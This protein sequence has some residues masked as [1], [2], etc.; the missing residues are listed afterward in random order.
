MAMDEADRVIRVYA[1]RVDEAADFSF[2][3]WNRQGLIVYETDD[4]NQAN[5]VGWDGTNSRN[6]AEIEGGTYSYRVRLQF[7]TGRVIDEIGTINYIK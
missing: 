2:Q 1:E 4:F 7:S 6:G 3:V 5:A